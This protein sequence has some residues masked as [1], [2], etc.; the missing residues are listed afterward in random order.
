MVVLASVMW[1]LFG[2]EGELSGVSLIRSFRFMQLLRMLHVDRGGG[3]W[4]LL[5]NVVYMHRQVSRRLPFSKPLFLVSV[6]L[7]C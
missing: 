6:Q 3:T 1:L 5:A 7:M 2:N 4:K